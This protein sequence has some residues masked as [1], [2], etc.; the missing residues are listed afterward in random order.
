M[1]GE[2]E[3]F[4]NER[5]ETNVEE[6]CVAREEQA[7]LHETIADITYNC[8]SSTGGYKRI[9]G[10]W[11]LKF[12]LSLSEKVKQDTVDVGCVLEP[13]NEYGNKER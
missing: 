12:D 10:C 6:I 13:Q 5:A 9:L 4:Q 1:R 11:E 7:I 2:T 8:Y 3:L